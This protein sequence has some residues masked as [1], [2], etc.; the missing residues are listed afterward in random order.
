MFSAFLRDRCKAGFTNI[1]CQ[2]KEL[3]AIVQSLMEWE[4]LLQSEEVTV[5]TDNRASTNIMTKKDFTG[6]ED[7]WIQ[8]LVVI[9]SAKN[10]EYSGKDQPCGRC[11]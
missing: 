5:H 3:F 4:H 2:Q 7:R 9:S 11:A 8:T 6:K 1:R 10:Q